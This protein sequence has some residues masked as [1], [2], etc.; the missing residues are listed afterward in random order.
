M[1]RTIPAALLTKIKSG[2]AALC[3]IATITRRDGLILRLTDLD[4]NLKVGG[5]I[6]VASEGYD[7]KAIEHRAGTR[8]DET[9]MTA[10]FGSS[11][12]NVQALANGLYS[13]ADV[14]LE[15]LDFTDISLGSRPRSPGIDTI[16]LSFICFDSADPNLILRFS[17]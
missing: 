8:V 15:G 11:Q 5:E 2:N 12:I 9:E 1:P 17:A 14:H 7:R 3:T 13:Y 10:L 16:S 6:Y 4:T